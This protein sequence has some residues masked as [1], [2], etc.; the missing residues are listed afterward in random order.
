MTMPIE[1]RKETIERVTMETVQGF[2]QGSGLSASVEWQR[3]DANKFPDYRAEVEGQR[4]AFEVTQLWELPSAAYER[5]LAARTISEIGSQ[6]RMYPVPTDAP[7]LRRLL[8]KA[9]NDKSEPSRLKLLNGDS[10]CLVVVNGQFDDGDAWAGVANQFDLSA[11]DSVIIVHSPVSVP[12]NELMEPSG[13]PPVCEVWKN[14]F[15]TTLPEYTIGDL[16]PIWRVGCE[17]SNSARCASGWRI[18]EMRRSVFQSGGSRGPLPWVLR[19]W[20]AC[21]RNLGRGC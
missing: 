20:R 4:W 3:P 15:G 16:F 8:E 19:R 5:R 6:W 21:M 11:F 2:L 14:G 18:P 10:Y 17:I 9:L 1:C 13:L 12:G 7:L